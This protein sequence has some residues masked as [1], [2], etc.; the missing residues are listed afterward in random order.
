MIV[1]DLAL[2]AAVIAAL[3]GLLWNRLFHFRWTLI[4]VPDILVLLLFVR[5]LLK[6]FVWTILPAMIA[7]GGIAVYSLFR[8]RKL[9]LPLAGA[10]STVRRF[11]FIRKLAAGLI[12]CLLAVIIAAPPILLPVFSLERPE[13]DYAIG[14]SLYHW[15]D[16]SRLEPVT[17]D[18]SDH[19]ELTV[20]VWYPADSASVAGLQHAVYLPEWNETAPLLAKQYHLPSFLFSH[21]QAVHTHGYSN[22]PVS[23]D[24]SRYPVILFSHGLPGLYASDTFLFEALASSGYIVVSIN[25][26]YYSIASVLQDGS[27]ATVQDH[28]FPSPLDW[29]ANDSL[30]ADVW[31]KDASFVLDRL[32]QL[33]KDP[34]FPIAGRLDWNRIGMAG[35]SF[36]GANAVQMLYTDDRVKAGVNLDGTMF[37]TGAGSGPLGKPLLLL[38]SKRSDPN[39]VP[40]DSELKQ[41]NITR[42]QFE[43]LVSEVLKREHN[44]L[45]ASGSRS[46]T[47][48]GAD[49]LAFTDLYR[50]SP[51]L[52]ILT[53]TGSPDAVH[54][55]ISAEVLTFFNEQLK[56]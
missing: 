3:A 27:V 26:T 36:G 43:K 11:A 50:F 1:I 10:P 38:L 52:P 33:D 42:A 28:A 18:P 35:H 23:A 53:G 5:L 6:P 31:A 34:S 41:S 8:L 48:K 54:R 47:I 29:D 46:M 9:R 40:T 12:A 21:L 24:L 20:Q 25:H 17:D 13:G 15:T 30:I 2:V 22:A 19:R 56:K 44:A 55:R 45:A 4:I 7:A 49:H 51:L 14:T 16:E 37:G 39:E 32:A